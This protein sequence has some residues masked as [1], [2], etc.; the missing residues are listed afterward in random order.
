MHFIFL[1]LDDFYVDI[2]GIRVYLCIIY[3]RIIY[4][5]T[6][7]GHRM[8][9]II[10][11]KLIGISFSLIHFLIINEIQVMRS[12]VENNNTRIFPLG[13]GTDRGKD[14]RKKN[15]YFR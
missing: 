12:F 7:S 11:F 10:F 13:K 15:N 8:F 4:V 6:I 1:F 14:I 9:D 2:R 5:C 3:V